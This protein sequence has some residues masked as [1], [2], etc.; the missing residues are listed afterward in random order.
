MIANITSNVGPQQDA[1]MCKDL[2]WKTAD[3]LGVSSAASVFFEATKHMVDSALEEAKSRG[4]MSSEGEPLPVTP[5]SRC[6]V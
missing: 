3:L 5:N 1:R 6:F 4:S 2:R